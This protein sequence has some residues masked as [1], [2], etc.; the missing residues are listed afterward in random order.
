[1]HSLDR[2]SSSRASR[3][4][5]RSVM[6]SARELRLFDDVAPRRNSVFLFQDPA[7]RSPVCSREQDKQTAGK[8]SARNLRR[9]SRSESPKES[10]IPAVSHQ[11]INALCN[12]NNAESQ[13]RDETRV[14]ALDS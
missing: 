4:I 7:R 12:A 14:I 9:R 3:E 10:L 2:S 6:Q 13:K 5:S 8:R 1:M 11:R